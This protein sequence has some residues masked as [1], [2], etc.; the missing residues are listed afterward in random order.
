[1]NS[2]FAFTLII[3]V[4][5]GLVGVIALYAILMS[6][7]KRKS[8]L[9][10]LRYSSVI[11]FLSYLISWGT[12]GYYYILRYGPEVKPIIKSGDYPW[13]HA[14]F[15]ETKEHLFLFLPILAFVLVLVFFLKGED[16]VS[17][18]NTKRAVAYITAIAAIIALF[19]T[20]SGILI[21]GSV[22]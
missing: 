3:H 16:I 19:I 13:A 4:M 7:F 10:F 1:M 17:N 21:S 12:G 5:S 14:F 2:I 11:A 15:M 9:T 22:Q 18:G 20:L 8:S 6:L